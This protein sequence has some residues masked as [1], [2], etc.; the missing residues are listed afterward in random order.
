MCRIQEKKT[1]VLRLTRPQ[2]LNAPT[3]SIDTHNIIRHYYMKNTVQYWVNK[4]DVFTVLN[5]FLIPQGM[6]PEHETAI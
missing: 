4:I 5:R 1:E 6:K 3:Q 2:H